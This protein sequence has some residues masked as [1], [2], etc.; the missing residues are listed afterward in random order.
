MDVLYNLEDAITIDPTL[1]YSAKSK[2]LLRNKYTKPQNYTHKKLFHN[3]YVGKTIVFSDY[4][5]KLISKNKENTT[6]TLIRKLKDGLPKKEKINIRAGKSRTLHKITIKDTIERWLRPRSIFGVTDLHFRDTKFYDAIDAK[7][8]SY[9]NLLPQCSDDVSFLEMLTLVISSKG[10]FSDSH[11]DDGDGSNHC[12]VG[13]KLWLAWDRTEG[14]M[15]GFQDCTYDAVYDQAA[16]DMNKFA[17]L[18]SAHWFIVSANQTLF[19]PGNFSHKVITLEPYIGFG[20]FYVSIPN[21]FNSYKRWVLNETS[22]VDDNF[23]D[24]MNVECIKK[25]KRISKSSNPYKEKLGL[26]YLPKAARKWKEGLTETQISLLKE[27]DSFK[28]L[29]RFSKSL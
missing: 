20:S 6:D 12:F 4:P 24:Y 2:N 18:K 15:K 21:Y 27:K 1:K 22:D 10:I 16:F 29:L 13:K 17:T 19:M 28:D 11:S 5:L 8:L 3:M 9:Y 7:A 25:F 23:L 14:R 26:N